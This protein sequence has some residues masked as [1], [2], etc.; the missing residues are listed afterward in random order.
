MCIRADCFASKEL[1][2]HT[3]DL[4]RI[5]ATVLRTGRWEDL[6][7]KTQRQLSEAAD[8][9]MEAADLADAAEFVNKQVFEAQNRR[10]EDLKISTN[11]REV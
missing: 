3:K 6:P 2:R 9:S 7:I 4:A 10:I 11:L 5:V 8:A 1:R